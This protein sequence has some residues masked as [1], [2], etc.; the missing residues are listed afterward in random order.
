MAATL[1]SGTRAVL[2][3]AAAAR[4]H[5]LDGFAD[6]DRIIVAIPHG[7]RLDVPPGVTVVRSRYLPNEDITTVDGIRV[8]TIA[9]A[10]V[11]LARVQHGSRSQALDAALRDGAA[12]LELRAAFIRHRRHGARGPT[13][14]ISMLDQ[15]VNARLPRSWFQRVAADLLEHSGIATVDEWVVRDEVGNVKAELDLAHV[16]LQVALE[17]QS[18]E[19][20]GTP[21]ARRAD[22]RRKRWL[23]RHG[24]EIIEL[25][26][27][28]LHHIDEV[29][30]DFLDAVDR[31]TRLLEA[32]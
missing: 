8:L 3:G 18:W 6:I 19:W 9:A 24:W 10:L 20:H 27:S 2:C 26:W 23:R 7:R 14:M 30:A 22:A 16:E 5:G 11:E 21:S 25:W 17:C 32:P 15:R 4:L 1:A 29:A 13:E 31:A 12:P 28:D